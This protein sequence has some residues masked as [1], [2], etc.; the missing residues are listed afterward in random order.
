VFEVWSEPLYEQENKDLLDWVAEEY[1]P[2][3]FQKEWIIPQP[4]ERE[5]KVSW[6]VLMVRWR[7]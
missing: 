2:F 6:K 4:V 5:W 7:T 3:G 1:L